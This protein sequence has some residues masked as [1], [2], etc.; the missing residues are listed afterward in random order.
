VPVKLTLDLVL[1]NPP[2]VDDQ[3]WRGQRA[4]LRDLHDRCLNITGDFLLAIDRVI[5]L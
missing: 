4:L 1:G 2:Q 5:H 3:W